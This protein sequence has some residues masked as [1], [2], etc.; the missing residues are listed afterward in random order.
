MIL[1]KTLNSNVIK[2]LLCSNSAERIC[3][4]TNALQLLCNFTPSL[5]LPRPMIKLQVRFASSTM[6]RA[7]SRLVAV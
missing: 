6:D 4:H 1:K 3:A 7:D 5:P 2:P